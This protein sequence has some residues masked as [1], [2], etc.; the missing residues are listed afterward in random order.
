MDGNDTVL[1]SLLTF[2][3]SAETY[4]GVLF[5]LESLSLFPLLKSL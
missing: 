1:E 5:L 2:V 3:G 4:I